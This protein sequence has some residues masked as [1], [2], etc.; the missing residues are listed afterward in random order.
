MSLAML[1]LSNFN[2]ETVSI[3]KLSISL[4]SFPPARMPGNMYL[5]LTKLASSP[6]PFP[7]FNVAR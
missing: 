7:T 2:F 1:G 5:K 3:Y 6:G 4:V